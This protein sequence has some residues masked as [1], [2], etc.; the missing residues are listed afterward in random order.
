[1]SVAWDSAEKLSDQL[2]TVSMVT[3]VSDGEN[4]MVIM[5]PRAADRLSAFLEAHGWKE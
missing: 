4:V 1:M 3:V 5:P 2:G